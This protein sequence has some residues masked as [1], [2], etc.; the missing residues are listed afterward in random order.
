MRLLFAAT[1][2]L[3][4][5]T[6]SFARDDQQGLRGKS[7]VVP[8]DADVSLPSRSFWN[9]AHYFFSRFMYLLMHQQADGGGLISD[10]TDAKDAV[11]D[12]GEVPLPNSGQPGQNVFVSCTNESW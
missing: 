9:D 1:A 7:P 10:T 5:T 4:A 2:L 3:C 6:V 12:L 8:P 11:Q